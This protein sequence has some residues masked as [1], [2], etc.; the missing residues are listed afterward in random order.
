MVIRLPRFYL[1]PHEAFTFSTYVK[2]T[3]HGT[4]EGSN[5]PSKCTWVIL[6]N[7]VRHH[8]KVGANNT[9]EN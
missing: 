2:P 5:A 1:K 8:M 7:M 3:P 4:S 6:T 9:L